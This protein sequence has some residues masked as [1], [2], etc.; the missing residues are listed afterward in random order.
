MSGQQALIFAIVQFHHCH[1]S[2]KRNDTNKGERQQKWN[3]IGTLKQFHNEQTTLHFDM[4]I[5]CAEMTSLSL[6]LLTQWE[7][8]QAAVSIQISYFPHQLG[9]HCLYYKVFSPTLIFN[10]LLL[11]WN[12]AYQTGLVQPITNL[13]INSTRVYPILP[14]GLWHKRRRSGGGGLFF[15]NW[16]ILGTRGYFGHSW[17]DQKLLS[18]QKVP[19]L[20]KINFRHSLPPPNSNDSTMPMDC[21]EGQNTN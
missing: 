4:K 18:S 15:G 8:P 17:H 1:N 16:T 10:I 20:P 12:K 9:K 11:I 3:V 2:L 7:S 6:Q 14:H 13:H 21:G 5:F 19:E